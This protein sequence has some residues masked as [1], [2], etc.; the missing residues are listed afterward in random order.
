M[1]VILFGNIFN[2]DHIL[3]TPNSDTKQQLLYI[4]PITVASIHDEKEKQTQKKY[5]TTQ[6]MQNSPK[7]SIG[8]TRSHFNFYSPLIVIIFEHQAAIMGVGA[9]RSL[10]SS[11]DTAFLIYKTR[12]CEC[13][14]KKIHKLILF[15]IFREH[16]FGHSIY[17]NMGIR[18][19]EELPAIICFTMHCPYFLFY[20]YNFI[21]K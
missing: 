14:R 7:M 1:E 19:N 17:K 15:F 12:I 4:V 6:G 9:A 20:A 10:L 16:K 13:G 18:R 21:L 2:T 5:D 3:R 8:E 11:I